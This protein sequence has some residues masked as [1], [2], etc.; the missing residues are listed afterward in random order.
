MR[1][2]FTDE[3]ISM[4]WGILFRREIIVNYARIQDIHLRSNFVE[5]WFGLA[6]VLVQTASGNAGAELALEGLKE[7]EAIRD[8]LY[9][10]MRGVKEPSRPPTPAALPAGATRPEADGTPEL[11][12]TL[13]EGAHELRWYM[14]TDRSLRIRSGITSLLESTMSFANV[15][16]VVV[17]QGPLQRLLRI[18]DVRVQSAGGR[19]D[20][21]D[22]DAGDSLHTGVFHGVDN[23]SAIRDL[24]LERLRRFRESGLGDPDEAAPVSAGPAPA[25]AGRGSALTAARELL[26]EARALRRHLA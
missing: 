24:I 15:Q 14:V 19:G 17:T 21:H 12:A 9:T 16:Q 5:R 1:Y 7:F 8:F 23:S 18:A 3:G 2:K 26:E 20:A 10:R 6:R 11:A 25:D 13:R 22:R 4:S